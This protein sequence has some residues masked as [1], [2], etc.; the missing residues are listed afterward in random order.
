MMKTKSCLVLC[1]VLLTTLMSSLHSAE[2]PAPGSVRAKKLLLIGSAP[3]N[4]PVGTHEYLPG[5]Q[6]LA[7]LLRPVPDVEVTVVTAEGSWKE[8]P[9]L[10][11]RADGV[12][13]FLTEGAA[14]LSADE[15]RLKAF[16]SLAARGGGL[17][18][19]HWGCGTRDAGP[20]ESFVALFGA[21]HGGPDRK[22]QVVDTNV[23][24]VD[25][26][27]PS[28]S[29]IKDFQVHEEFYYALKKANAGVVQPL[30][31]AVIEGRPEMVCWAF[32]R[33]DGGRGFGFTGL[34]FHENWKHTEYRRLLAQGVLWSLKVPVP[35]EFD[36]RLDVSDLTLPRKP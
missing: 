34:H 28:V 22:Y 23:R 18:V 6:L 14:W 32:E 27:H 24:V 10:L 11:E 15:K 16:Q 30:L 8:G 17:C 4:H 2:N 20:I 36:V 21:C 9:E 29:G 35:K 19:I 12:V 5:L 31:H 1:V 26:L 3:D 33:S 25:P 7:K 13:L